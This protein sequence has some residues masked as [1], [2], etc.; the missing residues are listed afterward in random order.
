MNHDIYPSTTSGEATG[1]PLS[2]R[3]T[4]CPLLLGLWASHPLPMAENTPFL[5]TGP[6]LLLCLPLGPARSRCTL[7]GFCVNKTYQFA[8]TPSCGH[9]GH[10]SQ[11]ALCIHLSLSS[12]QAFAPVV[13]PA[14][15]AL[16]VLTICTVL[17]AD[18]TGGKAVWII[19]GGDEK[20]WRR[21][22]QGARVRRGGPR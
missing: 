18:G 8:P 10:K 17:E 20:D 7:Q 1:P 22:K 12:L 9:T 4:S 6:K 2:P 11:P 21:Q 3:S 16:A 15:R 19:Q 14:Q 5:P 13:P